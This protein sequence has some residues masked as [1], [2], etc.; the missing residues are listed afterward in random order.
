MLVFVGIGLIIFS[1]AFGIA[2]GR[3]PLRHPEKR[4]R[5]LIAPDSIDGLKRL[6][7]VFPDVSNGGASAEPTDAVSVF[8]AARSCTF[9]SP[10]TAGS[11]D[12]KRQDLVC[13]I[14][15]LGQGI[16]GMVP[17]PFL[18]AHPAD[19]ERPFGARARILLT[20]FTQP[21]MFSMS[22]MAVLYDTSRKAQTPFGPSS[23][24]APAGIDGQGRTL[25]S[26]ILEVQPH[27]LGA[28]VRP[29]F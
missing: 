19:P 16:G 10:R 20:S 21:G 13:R 26:G 29:P 9:C 5:L 17:H 12:Q 14:G 8:Y 1:V 28:D 22:R 24:I 11:S 2:D 3:R 23:T 6:G 25:P 27:R 4:V 15:T 7:L 18:K